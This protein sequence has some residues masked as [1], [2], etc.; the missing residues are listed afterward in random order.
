M[1]GRSGTVRSHELDERSGQVEIKEKGEVL[2]LNAR[3]SG[4]SDP[5]KRGDE[6]IVYEYDTESGIYYVKKLS[7]S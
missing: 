3:L 6:V 4:G 7:T 2:L 5:L 1:V